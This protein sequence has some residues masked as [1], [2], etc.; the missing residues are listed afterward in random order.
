MVRAGPPRPAY[1]S[2]PDLKLRAELA[3]LGRCA[4]LLRRETGV[5]PFSTPL[6]RLIAQ[7]QRHGLSPPI[8]SRSLLQRW[9][10]TTLP[11]RRRLL[12]AGVAQHRAERVSRWRDSLPALWETRPGVIFRWLRGDTPV[13]GSIPIVGP[14]GLQCIS[15]PA[16]DAEVR[17]FWVDKVWC[18]HALDSPS[19]C[20]AALR[21]SPFFPFFPPPTS[22]PSDPWTPERVSLVLRRLRAGSAPGPRGLPISLWQALP[23]EVLARLAALLAMVEDTGVWPQELLQGYVALIPKSSGGGSRPQDQRPIAVLD[24]L[25]R[26]WAKGVT[27]SWAPVLQ[28]SY[29]GDSVLGFRAQAS[30]RHVAQLL[31]DLIGLQKRRQRPLWLVTFDLEKCFATLPWWAVFGTLDHAGVPAPIV[32]AFYAGL[33]QRFRLGQVD[34]RNFRFITFRVPNLRKFL[35]TSGC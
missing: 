20:W 5:G 15:V 26:L 34:R 17:S 21:L 9:V 14:S 31:S 11:E 29:L 16:V 33:R 2:G 19:D 7:L 10:T 4:S 23:Q 22:W 8:A 1:A 35:G 6:L 24:V 18:Q 12:A 28:G 32:R 3:A 25:Y 30:T 27:L 13:W